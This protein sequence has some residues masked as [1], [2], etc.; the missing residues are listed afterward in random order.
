MYR[1]PFHFKIYLVVVIIYVFFQL[2]NKSATQKRR[3]PTISDFFA[4]RSISDTK[5]EKYKI[6][7][8][9]INAYEL[10]TFERF[11]RTILQ[12]VGQNKNDRPMHLDSRAKCNYAT[13]FIIQEFSCIGQ[14]QT[15]LCATTCDVELYAANTVATK[16]V[17][18]CD[19][20]FSDG[21]RQLFRISFTFISR[22]VAERSLSSNFILM[23]LIVSVS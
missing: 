4:A 22:T 16:K 2:V 14:L 23:Y 5:P 8:L 20:D 21:R 19:L 17:A 11:G 1:T 9:K 3:Y 10:Q 18:G 6:T 13:N 12:A 7:A 15:D